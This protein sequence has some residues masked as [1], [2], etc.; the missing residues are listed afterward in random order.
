MAF[1]KVAF[2]G[3]FKDQ[4]KIDDKQGIE[5]MLFQLKDDLNSLG[6]EFIEKVVLPSTS[7]TN[8]VVFDACPLFFHIIIRPWYRLYGLIVYRLMRLNN[9]WWMKIK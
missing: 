8:S 4:I 6:T 2:I 1:P 3:T 9:S 5:R 7:T